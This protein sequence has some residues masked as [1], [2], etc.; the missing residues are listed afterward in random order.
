M[1]QRLSELQYKILGSLFFA[2]PYEAL[3]EE[4]PVAEAILKDELK[5]LIDRD[6]IQVMQESGMG[7]D[8]KRTM[9]FDSDHLELYAFQI[10]QKGLGLHETYMPA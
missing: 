6:W 10:T 9:F 2:E 7:G 3:K 1:S 8:V 5:I 4:V